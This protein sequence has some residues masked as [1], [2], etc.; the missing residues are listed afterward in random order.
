MI[1]FNWILVG[2]W[3]TVI[4]YFSSIPG[5]QT[6]SQIPPGLGHFLEYAFLAFLVL[7]AVK[8]FKQ[9]LP[10]LYIG[11][12]AV[13]ISATYAASDELHQLFVPGRQADIFDLI[14]DT[15]GALVVVVVALSA[16]Y[17]RARPKHK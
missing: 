8:S 9:K 11:G 1:I 15:L 3:M 10:N 2:A 7:R 5:D 13:A 12:W 6:P 17:F 16:E 4:F 14:I